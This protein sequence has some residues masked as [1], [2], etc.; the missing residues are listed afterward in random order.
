M[1]RWV[2]QVPGGEEIAGWEEN[3]KQNM[4][5]QFPTGPPRRGYMYSLVRIR[6]RK[7]DTVC[8]LG[9]RGFYIRT[10]GFRQPPDNLEV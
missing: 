10:Y 8:V 2:S 7:E 4:F 1:A 9:V 5:T 6:S 3:R